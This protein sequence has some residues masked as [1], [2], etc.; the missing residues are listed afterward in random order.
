MKLLG[1]PEPLSKG[2]KNPMALKSLHKIK[3]LVNYLL[4]TR[5]IDEDTRVVIEIAR[6]LNDKNKRKAIELWQKEREK[7]NDDYKKELAVYIVTGNANKKCVQ[8]HYKQCLVFINVNYYIQMEQNNKI[9][10]IAQK[11]MIHM[12]KV[13]GILVIQK[14]SKK[15]PRCT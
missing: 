8:L 3:D 13:H 2:F 11:K 14:V 15:R 10:N 7:E 12:L 5:K 9:I 4:Q 1:N 6:E